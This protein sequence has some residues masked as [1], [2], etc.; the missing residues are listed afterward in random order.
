M[1]KF[2]SA[3]KKSYLVHYKKF[4]N[5]SKESKSKLVR[6]LAGDTSVSHKKIIISYNSG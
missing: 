2:R 4:V 3:K 6:N 5:N 1:K